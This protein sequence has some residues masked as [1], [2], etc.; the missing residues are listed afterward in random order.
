MDLSIHESQRNMMADV[1][2][3]S[4]EMTTNVARWTTEDYRSFWRQC[5]E[6]GMMGFTLD[7]SLGGRGQSVVNAV[8]MMQAAG[9]GATHLGPF[10]AV[11]AHTY[12]GVIPLSKYGNTQQINDFLPS[13]ITG[14]R[15][16]AHA[17][18]EP[19]G[20]SDSLEL[21]TVATAQEGGYDITGEKAYI[22]NAPI[23]DVFMTHAQTN[24]K[25]GFLG[26]SCFLIPSSAEGLAVTEDYNLAGLMG[27]PISGVAYE[28][29][30]VSDSDTLGQI[31]QGAMIFSEAMNWERVLI[32]ALYVGAMKKQLEGVVRYAKQRKTSN[33]SITAHQAVS[34]KIADMKVRYESAKL[35][36]LQAAWDLQQGKARAISSS[37]SIAKYA[38]SESAVQN[39]LDAIQI[40]GASGLSRDTSEPLLDALSARIFSGTSEIQKNTIVKHTLQS[41]G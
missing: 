15:I 39:S 38:V 10:F 36:V 12:A 21:H 41:G 23:A 3:F 25:A 31:G 29:C 13:L 30:R 4:R 11:A 9:Y 7:P 8:L 34:H 16:A 19:K 24:P 28:H 2:D 32:I 17:I 5:G 22:S 18:T 37:S 27:A 20:G 26:L 6:I 40:R 1:A 33:G 14:E 35:L